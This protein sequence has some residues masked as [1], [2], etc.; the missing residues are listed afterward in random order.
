MPC[1]GMSS[2]HRVIFHVFYAH[3]THFTSSLSGVDATA[4]PAIP[5]E[6]MAGQTT[7]L[8]PEKERRDEGREEAVG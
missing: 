7:L 2:L 1:H 8:H 3:F 5:D 6:G 4:A